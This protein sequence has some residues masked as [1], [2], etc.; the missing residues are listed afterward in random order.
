[1]SSHDQ[2]FAVLF[3]IFNRPDT[4]KQVFEAI[5]QARPA[6][7]FVAADGPRSNRPEESDAC[8]QARAV[9]NQVDWDCKVHTL[10]R[11]NNL[12]CKAA[13]SSAIS[14]F[15]DH[16]EEGIILEDDCLPDQSFFSFCREL[17]EKYR[18]D[19]RVM[20]IAGHNFQFGRPV[21]TGSY[22]F[23]QLCHIW[24]WASWRRVWASYDPDMRDLPEF[25]SQGAFDRVFRSQ[26]MRTYYS[27]V[28]DQ[29]Y[30]GRIN[31]WD[32]QLA[33][34]ILKNNGLC[35]IPNVN[36]VENI[37]FTSGTH[38]SLDQFSFFKKLAVRNLYRKLM[39]NRK[40]AVNLPLVHP[41]FMV[42]AYDADRRYFRD[43]VYFFFMRLYIAYLKRRE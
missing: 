4:T 43:I 3:L 41:D 39:S 12:G 6:K 15:F 32:H 37:G 16:V 19:S 20:H 22:Y 31:T 17:L 35:I 27:F 18:H 24:G 11:E 14:W 1:M 28:F 33:Y 40:Q 7:L 10:F 8:R 9:V 42:T 34:T 38:T 13:V 30:R 21:G 5:R 29:V 26:D 2:N 36:L 23:S 25:S